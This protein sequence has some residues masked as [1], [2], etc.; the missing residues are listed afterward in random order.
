MFKSYKHFVE[1]LA[2]KDQGFYF[3]NQ[4]RETPAYWKMFQY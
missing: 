4:F 1:E 3:M 2:N